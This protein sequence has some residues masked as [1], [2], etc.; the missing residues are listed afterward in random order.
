[1]IKAGLSKIFGEKEKRRQSSLG[2]RLV[3]LYEVGIE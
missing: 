1:M 2:K 3:L